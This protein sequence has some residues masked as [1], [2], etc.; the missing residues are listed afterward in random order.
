MANAKITRALQAVRDAQWDAEAA[1]I[2]VRET[3]LYSY[4][5]EDVQARRESAKV[6]NVRLQRAQSELVRVRGY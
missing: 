3:E 4:P 5:R 6:A 1:M 2:A